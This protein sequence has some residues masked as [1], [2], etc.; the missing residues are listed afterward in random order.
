MIVSPAFLY[1]GERY[2][3]YMYGVSL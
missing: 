2:T 1:G 3:V